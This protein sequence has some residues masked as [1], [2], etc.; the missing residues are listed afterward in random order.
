VRDRVVWL[1]TLLYAALFT[2]LG[3]VR[4]ADHRNFVDFGIFAQTIASAFGCFCNAIEGSHWA[5]HFSPILY[6]AGAVVW[7]WR[8]P[9]ALVAMQAVACALTIP[10]ICG[11]VE[12]RADTRV[13]R[14]TAVALFLYP[15]LAGLTFGDFHENGFAP[16]AVA[17]MLWAFDGGMMLLA[18]GLALVTLCIKEDQAIFVGIA[19][20]LGAWRFR[21]TA[22]ARTAI[23]A[24]AAA[25]I[26]GVEYFHHIQPDA[27]RAVDWSPVRF[28]AWNAADVRALFPLGIVQRLGF[29]ALAFAPL[30]FLPFRSRMMWLAAAPLA[31]VLLSRMSTTF[32]MGSHYAGAWIGYVLVPFAFTVRRMDAKR[33]ARVLG[34]CIALCVVE[35]LVAD[36]LHPGLNLH[37]PQ[38]RDAA[39]DRALHSLPRDI[40]IATQEEAYTHLALSDPY[41]RLLPENPDRTELACFVLIDRDY[42]DSPRLQEYGAT[43]EALVS[44]GVYALA[45]RYGGIE[46]YRR[47]LPCR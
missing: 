25:A 15:A 23:V 31:E 18:L 22:A 20:V 27:A 28:Y 10:P 6:L 40:S 41:A 30:L 8:S 33:A 7:L 26:V 39:L 34:W 5:F 38:P 2:W 24:A 9:M 17:W 43:F 16:A 14:L 35:L 45:G 21:G 46:L 3:A 12:R 1:L 32:T 4:Y 37:A 29:F 47:V 36:P 13:V 44:S 19:G 11:L 42:P